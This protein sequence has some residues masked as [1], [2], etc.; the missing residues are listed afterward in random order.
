MPENRDDTAR[1]GKTG[2]FALAVATA[3]TVSAL[4]AASVPELDAAQWRAVNDGVMG[5]ISQGEIVAIPDGLR[6]QGALSLENN[7]G[8]ASVRRAHRAEK[9]GPANVRLKI[10]GDGRTYQFRV[11]TTDDYDGVSWRHDFTTDGN[12]QTMELPFDEFEP[13][14]R[15]RTVN[16]AG[17]LETANIRQ[18]GFLIADGEAGAFQLDIAE[19]ALHQA[20]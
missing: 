6:F 7:G 4:M 19:I 14:F 11:R 17:A 9:P 1:T 2:F 18:I 13:V 16:D 5:G 20:D 8:F 12:W 10:R 15:G 3:F